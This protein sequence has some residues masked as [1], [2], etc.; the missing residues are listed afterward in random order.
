MSTISII[1]PRGGRP[2][3]HSFVLPPHI[4]RLSGAIE[5]LAGELHTAPEEIL[6]NNVVIIDNAMVRWTEEDPVLKEGS[7][8]KLAPLMTGG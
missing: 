8:I 7:Y 5:W 2:K 1:I 6:V 4:T 3:K